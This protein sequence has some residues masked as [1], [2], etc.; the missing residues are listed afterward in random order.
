MNLDLLPVGWVHLAASLLAL[1]AGILVLLRPKGT[2]VHKRRGRIYV[3]SLLV[4]NVTALGIYR[5]GI[6]FFPHWLAIAALVLM[7]AGVLAARVKRPRRAWL[8]VHLTCQLASLYILVGG[9][10]NEAFLRVVALHQ[11]A[12]TLN[13]QAVRLTHSVVAMVSGRSSCTSMPW[14]CDGRARSSL[15]KPSR[16]PARVELTLA[17]DATSAPRRPGPVP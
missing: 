2:P 4:T 17:A 3:L 7:T 5:R 12:P 6:F 16:P 14:C 8:H 11:L 1:A 9:G 13:S 10:V 15:P